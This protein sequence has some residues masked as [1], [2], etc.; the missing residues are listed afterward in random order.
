V[1]SGSNLSLMDAARSIGRKREAD[2]Q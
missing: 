2:G 1:V